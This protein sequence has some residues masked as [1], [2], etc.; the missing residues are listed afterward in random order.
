MHVG[1]GR[2]TIPGIVPISPS[3]PHLLMRPGHSCGPCMD[4]GPR[5]KAG[6]RSLRSKTLAASPGTRGKQRVDG[7]SEGTLPA[8]VMLTRP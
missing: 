3:G 7:L 1:W 6:G 2:G 5:D 8:L 4:K